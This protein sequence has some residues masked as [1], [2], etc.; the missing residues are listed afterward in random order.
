MPRKVRYKKRK[1]KDTETYPYTYREGRTYDDFKAFTEQHPELCVVEIDT[2]K[3]KRE[4]GKCLLTMIF[5]KY[6][7]ML[8]FLLETA[9][10]ECV[11]EV[12]DMLQNSLGLNTF[13]RFFPVI[14]TDNGSEFKVPTFME[15]SRYGSLCTSV[16]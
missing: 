14:L 8:I 10:Q 7:F 6:D 2:V 16:F 1:E 4:K 12:F 13:R 9:S 15:K 5:T 3:G 11:K